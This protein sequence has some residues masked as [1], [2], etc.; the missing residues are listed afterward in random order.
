MKNQNLPFQ[1]GEHYERWEFDLEVLDVERIKGFDS[2]KY[3][4]KIEFL[5]LF[6]KSTELVFLM[7]MLQIVIFKYNYQKTDFERINEILNKKLKLKSKSK[8]LI[9]YYLD[10]SLEFW[11]TKEE[12]NTIIVSYGTPSFL[13]QLYNDETKN[14]PFRPF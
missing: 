12:S 11:L 5:G 2:Y 8:Q 3:L 4:N 7:D 1:I 10:S 14:N 9:N 6:T 13:S